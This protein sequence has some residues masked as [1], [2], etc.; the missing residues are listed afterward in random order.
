MR[1]WNTLDSLQSEWQFKINTHL[2]FK[3]KSFVGVLF[4]FIF[5][6]LLKRFKKESSHP[7]KLGCLETKSCLFTFCEAHSLRLVQ[8]L[9]PGPSLYPPRPVPFKLKDSKAHLGSS[10]WW[11]THCMCCLHFVWP[12]AYGMRCNGTWQYPLVL[13]AHVL[14]A[15]DPRSSWGNTV[16]DFNAVSPPLFFL[17]AKWVISGTK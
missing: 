12:D 2:C 1:K 14:L 16:V 5:I 9:H 3:T 4:S 11:S 13:L 8:I 6:S 17:R 7:K 10:L 15:E